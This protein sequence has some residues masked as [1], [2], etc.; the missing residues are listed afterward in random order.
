MLRNATQVVSKGELSLMFMRGVY[1]HAIVKLPAGSEFRTQN[2]IV[3]PHEATKEQLEFA[4]R[5]LAAAEQCAPWRNG[6]PQELRVPLY[7]R[8]DMVM[9]PSDDSS[10]STSISAGAGKAGI[11]ADGEAKALQPI[12]LSAPKPGPVLME[13]ELVEP[14]MTLKETDETGKRFAT[15][16]LKTLELANAE[17]ANR[18]AKARADAAH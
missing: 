18:A 10:A 1:S 3:K 12:E 5:V 15:A 11:S 14:L 2:G 9:V 8:V 16:L 13:L 17:L 6:R 4:S 7:A